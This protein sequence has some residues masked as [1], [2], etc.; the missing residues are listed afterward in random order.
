MLFHMQRGVPYKSFLHFM[1]S[2]PYLEPRNGLYNRDKKPISRHSIL[3]TPGAVFR[4]DP[5]LL[6]RLPCLPC[7]DGGV[8]TVLTM[9]WKSSARIPAVADFSCIAAAGLQPSALPRG[10]A[11]PASGDHLHGLAVRCCRLPHL[12]LN[13]SAQCWVHCSGHLGISCG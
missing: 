1:W 13:M 8:V 10:Q 11:D 3:M 5:S 2:A 4:Y 7:T 12:P 9:D 6:C